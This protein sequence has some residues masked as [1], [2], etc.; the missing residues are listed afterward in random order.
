[1]EIPNVCVGV[2]LALYRSATLDLVITDIM[3]GRQKGMKPTL[4]LI[5]EFLKARAY[6][7]ARS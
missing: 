1:M 2:G 3:L 4:M 6:S 7:G 5:R